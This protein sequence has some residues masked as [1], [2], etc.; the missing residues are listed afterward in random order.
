MF[1]RWKGLWVSILAAGATVASSLIPGRVRAVY[2]G[3]MDCQN[4]CDFIAAGWPF[5]YLVDHPGIS[6]IGSVSLS[7]G[8]IGEDL[9]W[10]GSLAATF[11]FWFGTC[12]AIVWIAARIKHYDST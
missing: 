2:P 10:F 1:Y 4:G 6:P 11:L 8:V 12:A 7:G 3:S 9:V 5:P